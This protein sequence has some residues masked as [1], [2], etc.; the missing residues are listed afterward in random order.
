MEI[1]PQSAEAFALYGSTL[2]N[3]RA[4]AAVPVL[5]RAIELDPEVPWVHGLLRNALTFLR[6][7]SEARVAWETARAA[8]NFHDS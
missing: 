3:L 7:G 5:R 2:I 8:P 1:D 4:A 6:R